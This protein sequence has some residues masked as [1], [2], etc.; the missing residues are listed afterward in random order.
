MPT[1]VLPWSTSISTRSS[2]FRSGSPTIQPIIGRP[3]PVTRTRTSV[4]TDGSVRTCSETS[5]IAR[6]VTA[7]ASMLPHSHPTMWSKTTS[8]NASA[9]ANPRRAWR[10]LNTETYFGFSVAR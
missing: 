7:I 1:A 10:D 2:W 8:A 4:L 6:M 3:Y 5:T 9:K